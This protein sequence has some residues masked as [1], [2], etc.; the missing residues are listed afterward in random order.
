M[1]YCDCGYGSSD[2]RPACLKCGKKFYQTM[3]QVVVLQYE[4]ALTHSVWVDYRHRKRS[5]E[6]L[7]KGLR[8]EI[9]DG[10]F[11]AYRLITIL[12]ESIGMPDMPIEQIVK[13]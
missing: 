7:L 10:R 1:N 9:N 13:L 11:V 5:I 8:K 12:G 4:P 2:Y 3:P 6:A